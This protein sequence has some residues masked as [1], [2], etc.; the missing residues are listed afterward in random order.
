MQGKKIS[1]SG[2]KITSYRKN[3]IYPFDLGLVSFLKAFHTNKL[4]QRGIMHPS[5][6]LL[7]KVF[8]R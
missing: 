8:S 4:R 3:Q 1:I 7:C 2:A 5:C 6:I